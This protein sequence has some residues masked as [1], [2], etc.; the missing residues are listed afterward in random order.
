MGVNSEL[1]DLR[2]MLRRGAL[3]VEDRETTRNYTCSSHR[4]NYPPMDSDGRTWLHISRRFDSASISFSNP[5]HTPNIVAVRQTL[6]L[7]L[8]GDYVVATATATATVVH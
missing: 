6:A 8:L 2:R 3:R 5:Y 4:C 7:H 1:N